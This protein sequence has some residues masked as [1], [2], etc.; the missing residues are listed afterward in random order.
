[1]PYVNDIVFALFVTL[2]AIDVA[3]LLGTWAVKANSRRQWR[4]RERYVRVASL[5]LRG[6]EYGTVKPPRSER[7][8]FLEAWDSLTRGVEPSERALE[9]FYAVTADW[10]LQRRAERLLGSAR[11][12]RRALGIR[13]LDTL[14]AAPRSATIRRRLP[15]ERNP[16]IALRLIVAAMETAPEESMDAIVSCFRLQDPGTRGRILAALEANPAVPAEWA[17]RRQVSADSDERSVI[18]AATAARPFAW[19]ADFVASC[20]ADPEPGVSARATQLAAKLCPER[21][22]L[23]AA[24]SSQNPE[25]REIAVKLLLPGELVPDRDRVR[26]LFENPATRDPAI[27]TLRERVNEQGRFLDVFLEWH[28]TAE[29]D[30][31]R[32]G[33]AEVLGA[34]ARYF[35]HR[36]EGRYGEKSADLI[37]DMVRLG[38][39]A[40]AINFLNE[41]RNPLR[42]NRLRSILEPCLADSSAFRA[43]CGRF[44]EPEIRKRWGV[45]EPDAPLRRERVAA[46]RRE[47][48]GF[49]AMMVMTIFAVP[50]SYAFSIRAIARFLRPA[51]LISGFVLH[52]QGLF[53][54]YTIA[55]SAIYLALMILS[56]GGLERQRRE[57]TLADRKFLHAP[58]ILPAVSVV[59]PAY[60][61]ETT[62]VQSVHSLLGLNYP[63]FEIIVVNDGSGD[64][65]FAKL[66]EAFEMKRI[67]GVARLPID[68]AP[69]TGMYRSVTEPNLYFID[70]LNG[71]KADSL[72]AGIGFAKNQ[73]VCTIDADSLLE[74]ETLLRMLFRTIVTKREI[75]ACGGNVIPINGCETRKGTLV[76]IHFPRGKYAK[77]QTIEYL[78]SFIAGRIGWVRLGGLIIISGALGV[79][80]RKR[81]LEVGGYLTGRTPLGRDTVGEDFEI[82]IRLT[83]HMRERGTAFLVD[84]AHNANCWTEVP[85]N[86]DDLIAQRDRWHRGLMENMA[87]HRKLLFNPRY[88]QT[89]LLAIPYYFL[90][91]LIGPFIEAIGYVMTFV[92]FF[93]GLLPPISVVMLFSVIVLLGLLVSSAALLLSERG[94]VYFQG[95]EFRSII[96]YCLL[97][98]LGYRQFMGILRSVSFV[99]YLRGNRGWRKFA[100]VGFAQAAPGRGDSSATK[101]ATDR[102][103][104]R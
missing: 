20:M 94:V 48:I 86:Q 99:G 39:S 87:F 78:R 35:L 32:D 88:R 77:Y 28:A 63:D 84:Y 102:G 80:S 53:L 52:V 83:R 58:G 55:V 36:L 79:F 19:T 25:I 47:R 100:R 51:E 72:N 9:W 8:R 1:L 23:Q 73:Y 7:S 76:G 17:E 33:W 89:G 31:E 24:L 41:N 6:A 101:A 91:E 61:E 103:A 46:T 75:V 92:A 2:L 21:I 38:F 65:T 43:Q 69:V 68:T 45:P 59:V 15:T 95:R 42:E 12:S 11:F 16:L 81:I 44:L 54:M 34:R 5:A 60:N 70:K 50:L 57:W 29:S 40:D 4:V 74:P 82:V 30:A 71:G 13:V 90:V 64:Q 96:A 104:R 93:L 66:V 67:D 26:A 3:V 37:A 85:D 62:I 49:G 10:D 14:P 97:E 18:L 98:N 56:R 27:E 22:D